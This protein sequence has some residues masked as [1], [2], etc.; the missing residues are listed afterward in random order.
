MDILRHRQRKRRRMKKRKNPRKERGKGKILVKR[1][2][3]ILIWC[4]YISENFQKRWMNPV[5]QKE[6]YKFNILGSFLVFIIKHTLIFPT[7]TK[8]LFVI[9]GIYVLSGFLMIEM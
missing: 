6:K 1:N 3:F 8:F 9:I 4:L 5:F 7:N 2:S